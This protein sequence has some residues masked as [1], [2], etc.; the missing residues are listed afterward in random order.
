MSEDRTPVV[1]V[2]ATS[3]AVLQLSREGASRWV[4]PGPSLPRPTGKP[5]PASKAALDRSRRELEAEAATEF[6]EAGGES[7]GRGAES[8]AW[9]QAFV[10]RRLALV[11]SGALGALSGVAAPEP[12]AATHA[13]TRKKDAPDH[14]DAE[15]VRRFLAAQTEQNALAERRCGR[16]RS[17]RLVASAKAALPGGHC[18]WEAPASAA[19][20]YVYKLHGATA[21]P[22]RPLLRAVVEDLASA[23]ECRHAVGACVLGVDRV[24]PHP[25]PSWHWAIGQL[26]I[27]AT[28]WA[29]DIG[30]WAYGQPCGHWALDIGHW[31][32]QASAVQTLIGR[33]WPR[34]VPPEAPFGAGK[35]CSA[36]FWPMFGG[37][38][39]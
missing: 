35:A 22:R 14:S 28:I 19:T 37:V 27:W 38:W 15:G 36:P 12:E 9:S 21:Q 5:R 7:A 26:G 25:N 31:A 1:C 34:L 8:L 39:C 17:R 13:L 18:T 24:R 10:R 3:L 30:H 4:W 16:G 29:L 20:A 11:V 23:A 32:W 6:A 33:G 2:D